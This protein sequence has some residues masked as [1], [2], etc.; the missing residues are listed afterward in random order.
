[1]KP[2]F[3]ILGASGSG[4]TTIC[5]Q[6][7]TFGYKQIPSYTTRKP[8]FNGEGGHTFLTDDEFDT[9]TDIV[10]YAV[11]TGARYCVTKDM[12]ENENYSLYVI[13]YTGLKYLKENYKGNRE[14]IGVFIDCDYD[15]RKE[16]LHQ[17][18]NN[19]ETIINARLEHDKKEFEGCKKDC[20]WVFTNNHPSDL[21]KIVNMIKVVI[22]EVNC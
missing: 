4:K 9:L 19:H 13:D 10:A 15:I 11:T 2:I 7:E 22:D 20:D 14:I 12:L 6:L 5:N 17:R 8:R 3:C 21:S 16:R 18:Y 1:M